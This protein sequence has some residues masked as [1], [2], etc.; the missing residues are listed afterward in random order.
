MRD[1]TAPHQLFAVTERSCRAARPAGGC[2]RCPRFENRSRGRSLRDKRKARASGCPRKCPMP[3]SSTVLQAG[4]P[5]SCSSIAHRSTGLSRNL[6][7]R[8]NGMPPDVVAGDADYPAVQPNIGTS[9]GS[10][11]ADDVVI[12]QQRAL[13]LSTAQQPRQLL[14]HALCCNAGKTMPSCRRIAAAVFRL[15]RK[16]KLGRK[17]H[18]RAECA[19]H[20]R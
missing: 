5:L 11:A 17:A 13:R 3:C 15:D 1:R 12:F 18:V 20:P 9:S 7:D 19:A 8:A 14:A 16:A 2:V 10:A 4:F 6:P